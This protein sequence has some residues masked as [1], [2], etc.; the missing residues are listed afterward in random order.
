MKNAQDFFGASVLSG[1][2]T[3]VPL[4]LP[5]APVAAPAPI[6]GAPRNAPVTGPEFQVFVL[7]PA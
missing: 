6:G 5:M 7:L 2:Y 4:P 1:T 3:G